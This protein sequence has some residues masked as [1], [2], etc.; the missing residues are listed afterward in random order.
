ML[1]IKKTKNKI[2]KELKRH[3]GL[4]PRVT[5]VSGDLM[6]S[7]GLQ[8][9]Y[10]HMCCT[11]MHADKN[12][13]SLAVVFQVPFFS[14][15]MRCVCLCV[16]RIHKA[17]LV[18]TPVHEHEEVKSVC[19]VPSTAVSLITSRQHLS[20]TKKHSVLI[21]W[22]ATNWNL[23]VFAAQCW[24]YKHTQL[25]LAFYMSDEDLNSV[26]MFVV[27]GLL[28]AEQ[29]LEPPT[30]FWGTVFFMGLEFGK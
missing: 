3:D 6:P 16:S 27:Q 28:S 26:L 25:C 17:M 2:K 18:F 19:W 22:L 7:C 10:T 8:R 23:P 5:S 11:Y 15:G 24:S 14:F 12:Q 21:G 9:H 30:L 13:K 1:R 20:L 29:F 4:Q